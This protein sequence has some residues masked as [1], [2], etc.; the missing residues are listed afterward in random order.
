MKKRRTRPISAERKD[1]YEFKEL[2]VYFKQLDE[3][4]NEH[5]VIAP[6]TWNMDETGFRVGCGRGRI[7]LTLDTQKPPKTADPD[8]REY[9][10]SIEAIN[11]EGEG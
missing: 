2:E 8:N 5:G 6:D 10:T 3:A 1:A 7:V 9:L 11:D 4:L